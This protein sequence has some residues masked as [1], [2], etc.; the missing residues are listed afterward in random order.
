MTASRG[1][2]IKIPYVPTPLPIAERMLELAAIRRGELL[3]D[4]GAGDG[5]LLTL[6]SQRYSAKAVGVELSQP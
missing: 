1:V 4:L 2:R 5:R 3:Y 6:A